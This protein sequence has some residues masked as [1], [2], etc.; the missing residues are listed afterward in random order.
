[1]TQ[2]D[3]LVYYM[4]LTVVHTLQVRFCGGRIKPLQCIMEIQLQITFQVY[5][6]IHKI[7]FMLFH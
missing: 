3:P 1:M 4:F 2:P 7:I 5:D 6:S